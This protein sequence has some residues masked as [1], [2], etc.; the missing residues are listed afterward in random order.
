[1][2]LPAQKPETGML[3]AIVES[4]S[5]RTGDELAARFAGQLLRETDTAEL[6]AYGTAGLARSSSGRIENRRV[7]SIPCD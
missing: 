1:M 6:E 5:S 4:L 2:T 3:A 7:V